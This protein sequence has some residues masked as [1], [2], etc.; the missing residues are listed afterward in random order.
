M[1]QCVVI[2]MIIAGAPQLATGLIREVVEGRGFALDLS[3]G[4]DPFPYPR[5][6]QWTRNG[7]VLLRNASRVTW[8]YP[9]V[10]IHNVSRTDRGQYSLSAINYRLDNPNEEIGRETGSFQLNVLCESC[11]CL[12]SLVCYYKFPNEHNR[13][14]T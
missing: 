3:I 9:S 5:D 10:V 2:I 7:G 12:H 1:I 8:G 4:R 11:T 14:V 6:F 13:P